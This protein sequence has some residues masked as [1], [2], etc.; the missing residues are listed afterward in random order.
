MI[1]FPCDIRIVHIRALFLQSLPALSHSL[2]YLLSSLFSPLFS[3]SIFRK[4]PIF[5]IL[6]AHGPCLLIIC[7]CVCL[8]RN[9]KTEAMPLEATVS[10][11]SL[12]R[13]PWHGSFW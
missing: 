13:K 8:L 11:S 7:D 4:P 10:S 12:I 1:Y 3:M 5:Y 2:F 9:S 6:C